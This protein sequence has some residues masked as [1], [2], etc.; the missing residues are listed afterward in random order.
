MRGESRAGQLLNRAASDE[1]LGV[2]VITR[3][4]LIVGCRNKAELGNLADLLE[5]FNPILVN[6]P[7]SERA[8]GL[9]EEFRLFHG[10]LIS[11]AFIAATALTR[12]CG[13]LT[14]NRRHFAFVPEI[15]LIPLP[16]RV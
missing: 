10:L 6:E 11:D 12:G 15:Q 16:E 2:S 4:E 13:L 5:R 8:A 7:I 3:M 9:L 14:K 1:A